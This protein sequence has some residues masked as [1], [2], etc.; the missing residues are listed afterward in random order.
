[1]CW[2]LLT[3]D[4]SWK[5]GPAR[6]LNS[7]TNVWER[8]DLEMQNLILPPRKCGRNIG[9]GEVGQVRVK[10]K[11]KGEGA[12]VGEPGSWVLSETRIGADKK[13]SSIW[14][15]KFIFLTCYF[16]S[17]MRGTW[18]VQSV[19]SLTLAPVMILCGLWVQVPCRALCRLLRAQSLLQILCPPLSLPLPC[20]H[21]VCLSLKNKE[22]LKNSFF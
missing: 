9:N 10:R 1:M 7:G 20:L 19:K 18:M 21:S 12:G 16:E 14:S 13:A 15:G 5:K 8:L 2:V 6:H 11:G 3:G 4:I 22:M 17:W